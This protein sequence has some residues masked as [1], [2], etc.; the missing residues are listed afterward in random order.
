M[1][2]GRSAWL[3][4]FKMEMACGSLVVFA[5]DSTR[6]RNDRL[7]EPL[8]A[9]AFFTHLLHPNE[10]FVHVDADHATH[11][12]AAQ[13]DESSPPALSVRGLCRAVGSIQRWARKH[14]AQAECI[15]A[16][17]QAIVERWLSPKMIRRYMTRLIAEIGS[18][19]RNA[20]IA[21]AVPSS[22]WFAGLGD[23][24][25]CVDLKDG[26]GCVRDAVAVAARARL[27]VAKAAVEAGRL[28]EQDYQMA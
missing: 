8:P 15:G 12:T 28:S 5:T 21:S 23:L 22:V 4:H 9:Y 17:G 3:D 18:R 11:P 14:P 19:Q 27:Q 10:H 24:R 20:N 6:P 26:L 16:K 25:H 7:W 1:L 13:A 2:Q